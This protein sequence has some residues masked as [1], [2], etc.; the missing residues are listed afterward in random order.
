MFWCLKVSFP[1]V[2]ETDFKRLLHYLYTD[3][4]PAGIPARDVLPLVEVADRLCLP[5]FLACVE[6]MTVARLDN[7]PLHES[8]PLVLR[9]LEPSQLHNAEQL[10]EWI[11]T[12]ASTNYDELCRKYA[13]ILRTLHPEN[14]AYLN[15]NRW[16]PV[17]YVS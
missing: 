15:K 16:P 17:W 2:S 13:K 12:F 5:R 10:A 14:Q 9:F 7:L 6:Q 1:G 11:L 4:L 8:A 3:R